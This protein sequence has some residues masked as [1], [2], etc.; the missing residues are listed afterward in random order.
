[1]AMLELAK[2]DEAITST[3]RKII[4]QREGS[5]RKSIIVCLE[6]DLALLQT[7]RTELASIV[8]GIEEAW[9][10]ISCGRDWSD[11]LLACVRDLEK[12]LPNASPE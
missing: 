2:T 3:K 1:M 12:L 7:R 5:D 4:E 6:R 9:E 10:E 8:A 11:S